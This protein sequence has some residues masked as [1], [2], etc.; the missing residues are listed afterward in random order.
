MDTFCFGCTRTIMAGS[1]L[2]FLLSL[3]DIYCFY[4]RVHVDDVYSISFI[5]A[6]G[7]IRFKWLDAVDVEQS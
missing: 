7:T 2:S 5:V 4:Y 6:A 3:Q 1:I